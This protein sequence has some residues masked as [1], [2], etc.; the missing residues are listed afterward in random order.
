VNQV[1]L[2][3][4]VD[5][6]PDFV[7]DAV[8]ER[9]IERDVRATWFVTHA[10]PAM[11]RLRHRPDLFELGIHPN[12][13]PGSSHGRTHEEVLQHCMQIVPEAVSIRSHGVYQ[14]G[15]LYATILRT[16]PIRVDSSTFLPEMDHI[17]PLEHPMPCGKLI[18]VPFFWAD[19]YELC[20]SAPDWHV[21]RFQG[22]PGLQI[23]MFHPINVYLNTSSIKSYDGMKV[24]V[25]RLNDAQPADLAAHIGRGPGV[26]QMFDRVRDLV[27]A[28]GGGVLIRNSS[29][30]VVHG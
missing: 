18:R 15:P 9:L 16:T 11:D 22:R 6:A 20:K 28:A 21:E 1:G 4:D 25:P 24:A 29:A 23:F 17:R 19:D 3:L 27:A 2:S 12:F 5:W 8:A 13:L 7:I 30:G 14:S 10:S 26:G